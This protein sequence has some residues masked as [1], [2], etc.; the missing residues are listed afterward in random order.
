M[1]ISTQVVVL[2]EV[3]VELCKSSIYPYAG[4]C[5]VVEVGLLVV[6]KNCGRPNVD[7]VTE[8]EGVEEEKV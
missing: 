2:V 4:S 8:G 7:L 3:G 1:L 6:W 5:E